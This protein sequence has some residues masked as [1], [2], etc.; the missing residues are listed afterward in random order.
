[1]KSKKLNDC[2]NRFHV[3]MPKPR[4]Q[5]ERRIPEAVLEA[6]T[7]KAEQPTE[8]QIK[9]EKDLED[10]NGW[11][12]R[13]QTKQ[14]SPIKKVQWNSVGALI[15]KFRSGAL[16]SQS[17]YVIIEEVSKRCVVHHCMVDNIVDENDIVEL[18]Y[19]NCD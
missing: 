19:L 9:L 10:E 8:K 6:K 15:K 4:D 14:I 13:A 11:W 16:H 12:T 7:K 17:C 3:A 5:K 1:M 2:L 18:S